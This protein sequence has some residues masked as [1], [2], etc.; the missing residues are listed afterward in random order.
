MR[1][2]EVDYGREAT[3][4][5][6]QVES[7]KKKKRRNRKTKPRQKGKNWFLSKE[8]EGSYGEYTGASPF[9]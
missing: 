4:K 5:E 9:C 3:R 8:E 2:L 6:K 7:A 1:A